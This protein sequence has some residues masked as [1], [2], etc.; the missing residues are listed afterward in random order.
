MKKKFVGGARRLHNL[1]RVY[2]KPRA[3]EL[4]K[5]NR[6]RV[7]V[8]LYMDKPKLE[9]K[10]VFSTGVKVRFSRIRRQSLSGRVSVYI[11]GRERLSRAFFTV[12]LYGGLESIEI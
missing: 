2:V 5:Y 4:H 12:R 11:W 10:I 9:I 3:R 6:R 8:E 7:C 1:S